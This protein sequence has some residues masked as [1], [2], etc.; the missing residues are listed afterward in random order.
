MQNLLIV[1]CFKPYKP[2]QPVN[3]KVLNFHLVYDTLT[4]MYNLDEKEI[5]ECVAFSW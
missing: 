1:E 5:L 3:L 4:F 2:C